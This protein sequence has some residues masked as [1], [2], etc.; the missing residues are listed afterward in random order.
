MQDP[1]RYVVVDANVLS[2]A[3]LPKSTGSRQLAKRA[4][5]LLQAVTK[6]RWPSLVLY[7]PAICV[8]EALATF[9]KYRYCTWHGDLKRKPERQITDRRYRS[10]QKNL[11]DALESLR[12]HRIQ[13]DPRHALAAG[14]VSPINAF[15]EHCG[16]GDGAQDP[17]RR[18]PMSATDCLIAGTA[19]LL[20]HQH[21][22]GRVVLATG[23]KRL[24]DVMRKAKN[25]TPRE[26]G[27]L[28]LQFAACRI[29]LKDGWSTNVYPECVNL[30]QAEEAELRRAFFGWP[31]P[32]R[33]CPPAR[34]LTP[35]Q[36]EK[37]I[38]LWR[39]VKRDHDL[40]G[41]DSLPYTRALDDLRTRFAVQCECYLSN[42]QIY[43]TLQ[44]LRKAGKRPGQGKAGAHASSQETNLFEQAR[45]GTAR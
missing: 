9:D 12:L 23:D 8:V 19:I 22:P 2:A 10:A 31:L 15:F 16:A 35:D 14:L 24:S 29:G 36:R 30:I 13:H 40:G 41:E 32:K 39:H 3:L 44:D 37:L 38:Q 27:E 45:R 20:H 7:T 25:I 6:A 18:R 11:K 1:V 26:A 34:Q 21:G 42:A 33:P 43:K 4:R 17:A 5:I 28:G